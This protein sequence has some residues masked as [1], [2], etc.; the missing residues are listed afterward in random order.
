MLITL[1]KAGNGVFIAIVGI[2]AGVLPVCCRSSLFG[3]I[4]A[5]VGIIGPFVVLIV[6]VW[7]V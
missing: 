7:A 2:G 1:L 3:D 4:G 5:K 6:A